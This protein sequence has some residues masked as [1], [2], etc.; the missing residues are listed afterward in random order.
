MGGATPLCISS[1]RDWRTVTSRSSIAFFIAGDDTTPL[2]IS[3]LLAIRIKRLNPL[4][5]PDNT[6]E[7]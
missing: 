4:R 7:N 6:P 3:W 2:Q 5:A 1:A